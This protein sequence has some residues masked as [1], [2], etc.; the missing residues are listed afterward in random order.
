MSSSVV[1]FERYRGFSAVELMVAMTLSL[2]LIAGVLSL[3]YSSKITYLENERVS[4]NQ[5]GGR[6][7]FE[8]ILRDVRGAGF[9]GCAPAIAKGFVLNNLLNNPGSLLW[10]LDQPLQGYEGS[11]G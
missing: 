9:Q 3:V 2:I 10:Q 6:A 7:A 4:R 1:R 5:E 11:S 8:M